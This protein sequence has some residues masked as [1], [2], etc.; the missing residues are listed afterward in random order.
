VPGVSSNVQTTNLL[1]VLYIAIFSIILTTVL[2]TGCGFEHPF[3]KGVL[4]AIYG[5]LNL[6]LVI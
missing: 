1:S 6:K 4:A 5:K 3:K 2:E